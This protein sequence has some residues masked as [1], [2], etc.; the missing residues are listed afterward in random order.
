MNDTWQTTAETWWQTLDAD[1][2]AHWGRRA[3]TPAAAWRLYLDELGPIDPPEF[4]P[5]HVLRQ[6]DPPPD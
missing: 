4:I 5:D 3:S 6:F 2:R 1:E